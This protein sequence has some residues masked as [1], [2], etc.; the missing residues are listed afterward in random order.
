[1][2]WLIDASGRRVQCIA[3]CFPCRDAFLSPN[4]DVVG[5][6]TTRLGGA[7]QREA[8]VR[9]LRRLLVAELKQR[10]TEEMKLAGMRAANPC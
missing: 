1:M 8:I 7:K 5:H 2:P 3:P 9:V 6:L 10:L 4:D